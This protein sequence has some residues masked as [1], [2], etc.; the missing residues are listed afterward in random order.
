MQQPHVYDI[1]IRALQ[2]FGQNR[3]FCESFVYELYN[4]A[5]FKNAI[6][7]QYTDSPA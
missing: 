2:G 6:Y 5:V 3:F 4:R 1:L 7:F